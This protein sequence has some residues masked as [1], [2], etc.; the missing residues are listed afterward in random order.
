MVCMV[1][2]VCMVG[3]YE[4]R[5]DDKNVATTFD[6]KDAPRRFGRAIGKERKGSFPVACS[7]LWRMIVLVKNST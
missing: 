3:M 7:Y 6:V 4:Y 1:C 5:V 2:M